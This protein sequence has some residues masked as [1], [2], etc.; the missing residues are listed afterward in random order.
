MYISFFIISVLT[1][2]ILLFGLPT[3]DHPSHG[4]L[5]VMTAVWLRSALVIHINPPL[6]QTRPLGTVGPTA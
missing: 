1:S 6:S 5:S 4:P 3:A 2:P